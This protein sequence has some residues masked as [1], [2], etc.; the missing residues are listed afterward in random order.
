MTDIK[1]YAA[2]TTLSADLRKEMEDL[3]DKLK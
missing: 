1:Q 3:Y 2:L